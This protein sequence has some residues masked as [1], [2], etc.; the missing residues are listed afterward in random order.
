MIFCHITAKNQSGTVNIMKKS[1]L[2]RVISVTLALF[3]L[4]AFCAGCKTTPPA[5]APADSTADKPDNDTTP[6][7]EVTTAAPPEETTL[8][9]ITTAPATTPSTT[10]PVVVTTAPD[11]TDPEPSAAIKYSSEKAPSSLPDSNAAIE[12]EFVADFENGE[13]YFQATETG[14]DMVMT[15]NADGSVKQFGDQYCSVAKIISDGACGKGGL[16]LY[17]NLGTK[18]SMRSHFYVKNRVDMSA[19][20]GLMLYV[21]VT[22]VVSP[23]SSY[24]TDPAKEEKLCA[25][26]VYMLLSKSADNSPLTANYSTDTEGFYSYM[27]KTARTTTAYYYDS[28]AAEWVKTENAYASKHVFLVPFDFAGYVYVPFTSYYNDGETSVCM[29]DY[30]SKGY[31]YPAR[32]GIYTGGYN[33][34]EPNSA[35]ILVDEISFV[36]AADAQS[37]TVKEDA[38][39]DVVRIDSAT[40]KTAKVSFVIG[41]AGAGNDVTY[42]YSVGKNIFDSDIPKPASSGGSIFNAW[43][44]D[45]AGNDPCDPSGYTVN[46]DVTFYARWISVS[47]EYAT[48]ASVIENRDGGVYTLP[49]GKVIFYGASNFTRWTTLEKDMKEDI[50]ALNHGIGGAVDSNLIANLQRLV[51]QYKPAAVVIQC[52]NNDVHKFTDEQCKKTKETLYDGIHKALPDA[53]IIFVSHMPLPSRTAYW[54]VTTRLQQLN[55]WMKEFCETHDN[56]EY[57][58]VWDAILGMATAYLGG[59]QSKYFNDGSHFNAAGQAVFCSALKPAVTAIMAKYKK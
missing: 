24:I 52:S 47:T 1:K 50:D 51:I 14:S 38:K 9:D 21:D 27:N 55:V 12:G 5:P 26:S 58:D 35:Y 23:N 15:L 53:V 42:E 59:N 36:R 54:L 40:D 43:T 18:M 31:K 3:S 20:S 41:R 33:N 8:G 7:A 2:L 49:E 44:S 45:S 48:D 32:L 13:D 6:S 30:I 4:C 11:S 10:A 19:Y 46:G 16:G 25:V 37:N 56:C 29:T 57:I 34:T 17:A 22:H 39:V 28:K